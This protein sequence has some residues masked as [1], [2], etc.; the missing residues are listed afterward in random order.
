MLPP[1]APQ[2]DFAIP[3]PYVQSPLFIRPHDKS[4]KFSTSHLQWKDVRENFETIGYF[5]ECPA[6]SGKTEDNYRLAL[7]TNGTLA[8]LCRTVFMSNIGHNEVQAILLCNSSNTSRS[9]SSDFQAPREVEDTGRSY[10]IA[11]EQ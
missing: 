7:S 4:T 9:T 1:L 6:A 8:T 5:T 10:S 2:S 11:N 3:L